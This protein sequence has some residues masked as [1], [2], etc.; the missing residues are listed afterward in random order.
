MVIIALLSWQSGFA[1]APGVMFWQRNALDA[2]EW[3]R[4][5][6]AHAVHLN[7]R[8]LLVNLLG[9]L[10]LSEL[11]C[12]R[13][14]AIEFLS[15]IAF[16]ALGVSLLLWLLQPQLSW[17]CGLSGVLHGLWSASAGRNWLRDRKL[18]DLI[19][20]FALVT[21]LGCAP[22]VTMEIPVIV[23]AHW[24]GALSGLLWLNLLSLPSLWHAFQRSKQSCV[25]FD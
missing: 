14:T 15:L 9:L 18:V 16:S 13:F 23:E 2:G 25:I 8:H 5:F 20:L 24:Y 1:D 10:L 6:S 3:W 19:A 11:L 22:A 17:Y 12:E 4:L 21:K 7:Q